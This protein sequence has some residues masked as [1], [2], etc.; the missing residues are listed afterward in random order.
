MVRPPDIDDPVEAPVEFFLVVGD[1][2]GEIGR[3]AVTADEH[4]V[5]LVGEVRGLEPEGAVLLEGES[6]VFQGFHG[7]GN[8]VTLIQALLGEPHVEGHTEVGKVLPYGGEDGVGGKG[9][10]KGKALFGREGEKT[11]A[12]TL[13][14]RPGNV[15]DV[16]ALVPVRREGGFL[17]ASGNLEVARL[18]GS[19]E[20]I[21]LEP[22]VVDVV[23]PLNIP[24]GE[25]QDIG[26]DVP[27][28]RAPPVPHMQWT[29]GVGAHEF[30]LDP[31]ASAE[32]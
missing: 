9:F 21:H 12:F 26:D 8:Q 5:L 22:R 16:A 19:S 17:R 6:A 7:R 13:P 27:H 32:M 3:D 28:G 24:A 4:P 14:D 20:N 18:G 30:H 1:V 10:E 23:L 2:G 25:V 29:G 15:V 31:S 11:V